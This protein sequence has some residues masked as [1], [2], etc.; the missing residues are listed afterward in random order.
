MLS[1][2]SLIESRVDYLTATCLIDKL[3]TG[4]E[5]EKGIAL[6]VSLLHDEENKGNDRKQFM[7]KNFIGF[8]SGQATV[9]RSNRGMLFRL[10]GE[11]ARDRWKEVYDISTNVSRV[12]VAATIKLNGAWSDL[13]R[14]HL[15]EVRRWARVSSP[16]LQVR[17]VDGGKDGSS[18][19]IG[20][21]TSNAYGR[22]YDKEAESKSEDY[23][24]CWRYEVEYKKDL[25]N[26]ACEHMSASVKPDLVAS[27]V[28]L[29]WFRQHGCGLGE[30]LPVES[31]PCSSSEAS[32]DNRRLRWLRS[33]VR[34]SIEG[35]TARGK[36]VDVLNALG[37]YSEVLASVGYFDRVQPEEEKP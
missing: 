27:S 37:L 21:R 26:A 19:L 2:T 3:A 5:I 24:A 28:A 17:R 32:D 22:I 30:I 16:R 4:E 29:E 15:D 20:N 12:D 25:A 18:L 11:C 8:T 13:S 6:S 33:G 34:R 35:L 23:E 14:V 36:L 9:A 31:L 1:H 7:F 10:S